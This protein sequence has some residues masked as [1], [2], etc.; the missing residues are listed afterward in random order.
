MKIKSS[1]AHHFFYHIIEQATF[2]KA[3]NN[4]GQISY[5][6]LFKTVYVS[7]PLQ[8]SQDYKKAFE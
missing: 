7:S 6:F 3:I 8:K 4:N 5:K 2:I 1:L